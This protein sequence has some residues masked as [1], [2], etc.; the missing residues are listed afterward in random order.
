MLGLC[1]AVVVK[2]IGGGRKSRYPIVTAM[3]SRTALG[4]VESQVAKAQGRE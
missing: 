1:P 4:K 2:R 3:A